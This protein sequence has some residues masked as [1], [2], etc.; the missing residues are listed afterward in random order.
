MTE[1]SKNVG[2]N[3][4]EKY[5]P[6]VSSETSERP[7]ETTKQA[8]RIS[9]FAYLK[10]PFLKNGPYPASFPLFPSLSHSNKSY[11]LNLNNISKRKKHR[12]GTWESNL[13]PQEGRRNH[14]AMAAVLTLLI[15]KYPFWKWA[16]SGLYSFVFVFSKANCKHVMYKILPMTGM[17]CWPRVTE[18]TALSTKPPPLP[19][20]KYPFPALLL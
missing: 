11:S 2:G 5:C 3:F 20:Q 4:L 1:A 10:V 7:L 8:K 16:F 12:W 18:S 6:S 15:F 17:N 13:G 9:H 19:I 14:G